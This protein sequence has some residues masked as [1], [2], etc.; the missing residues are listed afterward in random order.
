MRERTASILVIAG[1][2]GLLPAAGRALTPYSQDFE[3]L[4]QASATALANDGWLVYGNVFAPDGVTYLYGY[5]PYPAPNDGY[6]FCQIVLGEGGVEQGAQQL[7]AFSDYENLDH[8]KGYII[9][10][11]VYREQAVTADAVGQTWVFDF[12]AKLG[13]LEGGSTAAAFIKTINPSAGYVMTNFISADM[14]NTPATWMGYSLSI[15]IDTSLVGQLLQIGFLNKASYYEGSGIFYD[16]LSFHILDMTDV[17]DQTLAGATLR[18]NHPNPF[19]PSTQI[20]FALDRPG[21]VELCVFDLAGR[22]IATLRRDDLEAGEHVVTWNGRSDAG[23][24]VPAG[25]YRCVLKTAAG[26]VSRSMALVK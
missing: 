10:A 19:N 18:Q 8:A 20:E 24:P 16:N 12:Q 26:R 21:R 2:V 5:G 17:P 3:S 25:Q 1:L 15:T 23:T 4:N 7:V 14:T 6:A 13:N 9:E 11:N 22:R